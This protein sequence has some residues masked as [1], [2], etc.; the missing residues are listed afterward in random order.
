VTVGTHEQQFNRL[1]KSTDKLVAEGLLSDEVFIQTGYST[2]EPMYCS[3]KKFI[4]YKEMNSM[5]MKSDVIVTHGGP[6][7]FIEVMANGKTPVVVP[8][9]HKFGEHVNDH[10]L[11]FVKFLVDKQYNIIPVYDINDLD[12]AIAKA[13]VVADTNA[14]PFFHSGNAQFCDKLLNL[15]EGL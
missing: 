3:W 9:Q 1:I 2:Y 11:E 8:R 15:I 14:E 5:I 6:S 13:K 10:Q 7:S 12:S 4:S